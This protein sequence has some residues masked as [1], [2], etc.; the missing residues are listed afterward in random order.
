MN[1]NDDFPPLVSALWLRDHLDDVVVVDGS[2]Y[3]ASM[4]RDAD[5]EFETRR[6]AG[7][8]RWNIDVIAEPHASLK[9]MMPSADVVARAAGERGI[10]NGSTVIIYDQLGMFSAARVWLTFKLIGHQ[11]VALLD[12]GLPAWEGPTES[13][14]ARQPD[15]V[16]YGVHHSTDVTVGRDHVA[17]ALSAKSACIIDARA[18]GRFAGTAPEPVQGLRSGHM[19]G[20]INLPFTDLLTSDNRFKSVGELK[21]VFADAG[22]DRSTPIITSCGSGVTAAIVSFALH[23]LETPSLVYDGSWSEWGQ[24]ELNMPVT[25][26]V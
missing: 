17:Q 6:I 23:L 13:G 18:A 2:Y 15:A 14:E 1:S 11:R 16:E 9:H 8:T 4:G 25:C 7:A 19:P 12:G 22:V 3:L 20:A 24:P 10:S 21:Q 5:R 26:E